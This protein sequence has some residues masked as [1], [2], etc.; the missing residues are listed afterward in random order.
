LQTILNAP[1]WMAK[2]KDTRRRRREQVIALLKK[3]L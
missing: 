2:V 1:E 3:G